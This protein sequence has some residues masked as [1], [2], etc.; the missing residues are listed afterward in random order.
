M[1]EK[2]LMA[3]AFHIR[4]AAGTEQRLKAIAERTGVDR[5]IVARL[6]LNSG[7]V[8]ISKSLPAMPVIK[9]IKGEPEP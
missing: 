6:A 7:L 9:D 4:L 3:K 1:R 2:K 8:A 5:T